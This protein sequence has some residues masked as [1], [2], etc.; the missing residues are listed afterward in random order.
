MIYTF[1]LYRG[2]NPMFILGRYKDTIKPQTKIIVSGKISKIENR[3]NFQVIIYII[4][5]LILSNIY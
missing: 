2:T 5:I 4:C 1:Y 3:Q